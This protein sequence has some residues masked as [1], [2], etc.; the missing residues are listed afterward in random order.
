MWAFASQ[1]KVAP[2]ACPGCV[3]VLNAVLPVCL[4]AAHTVRKLCK[5]VGDT[6]IFFAALRRG[7]LFI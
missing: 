6:A 7:F 2:Q 3:A 4:R 5:P 1:V